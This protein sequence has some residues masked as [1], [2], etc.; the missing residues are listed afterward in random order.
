MSYQ[1]AERATEAPAVITRC[2]H[3]KEVLAVRYNGESIAR[4]DKVIRRNLELHQ[5]NPA[6]TT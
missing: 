1:R 5:C 3:C 6:P 2:R 4:I